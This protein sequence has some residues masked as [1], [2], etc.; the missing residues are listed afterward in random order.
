MRQVERQHVH[1]VI[2]VERAE[3]HT[4]DYAD[5]QALPCFARRWNSSNRIV[6]SER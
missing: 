6:V 3:L 2:V 1:F 5:S 4:S